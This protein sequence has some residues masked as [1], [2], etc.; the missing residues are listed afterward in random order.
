MHLLA[1]PACFACMGGMYTECMG[2]CSSQ[3]T[4]GCWTGHS[5]KPA[6]AEVDGEWPNPTANPT[7]HLCSLESKTKKL[8]LF[9]MDRGGE[10]SKIKRKI[11]VVDERNT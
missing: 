9:G 8:E 5:I 1:R 6:C 11:P 2:L 4:A 10:I 3:I 7:K